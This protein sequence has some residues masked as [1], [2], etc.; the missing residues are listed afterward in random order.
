M[1][2]V[3]LTRCYDQYPSDT[4]TFLCLHI[5][6]DLHLHHSGK[7]KNCPQAKEPWTWQ[8]PVPGRYQSLLT[9]HLALRIGRIVT[10]QLIVPAEDLPA[11]DT[12][13]SRGE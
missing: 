6:P 8:T 10:P 12:H 3:G 1:I 13:G 11:S 9:L 4:R 7:I 5:V 2:I